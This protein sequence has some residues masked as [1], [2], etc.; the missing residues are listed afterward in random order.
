[1]AKKKMGRPSK[2][3][4]KYCEE[5]IDGEISFSPMGDFSP[6]QYTVLLSS[7]PLFLYYFPNGSV[8]LIYI[9]ESKMTVLTEPKTDKEISLEIEAE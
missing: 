4:V 1:M 8:V 3:K 7:I 2:Y 5:L 6:N 9:T